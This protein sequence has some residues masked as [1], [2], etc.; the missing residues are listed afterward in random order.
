MND[1]GQF[2][3]SMWFF[4]VFF[5][6]ILPLAAACFWLLYSA[7][8]VFKPIAGQERRPIGSKRSAKTRPGMMRRS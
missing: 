5:F 4:P 3:V 1:I 2:I 8:D 7:F 6:I